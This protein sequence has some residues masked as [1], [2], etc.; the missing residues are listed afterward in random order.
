MAVNK[1]HVDKIILLSLFT[2]RAGP[3]LPFSKQICPP[4]PSS[5]ANWSAPSGIPSWDTVRVPAPAL[6]VM[7][8]SALILA[9]HPPWG[10][11]APASALLY[12]LASSEQT[13]LY[14]RHS[15]QSLQMPCR[16]KMSTSVETG[17][18]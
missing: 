8:P 16:R 12:L 5:R 7:S 4:A 15:L 6:P 1:N 13:H 17:E 3:L 11:P 10:C 18:C 9:A 2:L 14:P